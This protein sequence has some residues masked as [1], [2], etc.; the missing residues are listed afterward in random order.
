MR[1]QIEN[2]LRIDDGDVLLGRATSSRRYSLH[3][4]AVRV[5]VDS[6]GI[7]VATNDPENRFEDMATFDSPDGAYETVEIEGHEG[8]WVIWLIPY[9]GA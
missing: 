9:S 6:N 1:I 2:W 4:Y 5:V 3:A 7:Q 8:D